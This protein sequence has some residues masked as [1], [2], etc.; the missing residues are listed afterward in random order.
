MPSSLCPPTIERGREEGNVELL[1]VIRSLL[2][3]LSHSGVCSRGEEERGIELSPRSH[4]SPFLP[5]Q[6]PPLLLTYAHGGDCSSIHRWSEPVYG[7]YGEI[8]GAPLFLL[9]PCMPSAAV[10]VKV[11][12]LFLP[13]DFPI[14]KHRATLPLL[15][16][17]TTEV[18]GKLCSHLSPSHVPCTRF[19]TLPAEKAAPPSLPGGGLVAKDSCTI[20]AG[21]A[22]GGTEDREVGW[23]GI[24]CRS[25]GLFPDRARLLDST[26]AAPTT[27]ATYYV[28]R[29]TAR[30]QWQWRPPRAAWWRDRPTDV[31]S[32]VVTLSLTR[33]W[34]IIDGTRKGEEGSEG[35]FQSAPIK[36]GRGEGG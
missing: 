5:T 15:L 24:S 14:L 36:R 1:G 4:P 16:P 29:I 12:P 21:G 23:G 31:G 33:D 30:V 27:P 26:S 13:S 19:L 11:L 6:S 22:G 7:S 10:V 34:E 28:L 17:R 35:P 20:I 18:R 25:V 32:Q 2:L 8:N 3:S 9:R